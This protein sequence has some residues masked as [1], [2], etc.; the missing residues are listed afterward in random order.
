MCFRGELDELWYSVSGWAK[1]I[2]LFIR[3][4]PLIKCPFCN[5]AGGE[6]SGYYEREWTECSE[7]WRHWDELEDRGINW[8]VG[9]MPLLKFIRAKL[10]I[11]LGHWRTACIRELIA[12]KLGRHDWMNED[13]AEPGLRICRVCYEHKSVKDTGA[14]P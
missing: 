14:T 11:R 13:E 4:R 3:N 9:R 5:G 7:C 1:R 10:S 6:M 2:W 12:C 8:V